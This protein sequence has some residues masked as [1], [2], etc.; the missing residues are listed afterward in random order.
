MALSINGPGSTLIVGDSLISTGSSICRFR[1]AD[2][3]RVCTADGRQS[4]VKLSSNPCQLTVVSDGCV[5]V[6]LFGGHVVAL[7][8]HIEPC[9]VIGEGRLHISSGVTGVCVSADAVF[10]SESMA[11]CVSVFRRVDG[12]FVRRIGSL[13]GG[14]VDGQLSWPGALCLTAAGRHIAVTDLGNHRV[15]VFSVTGEFVRNVGAGVLKTPHGIACSV[16]DELVVADRGNGC[17]RVFSD[18]GDLLKTFGEGD[19]TGVV[20]AGDTVL[21]QDC[22]GERCVVWV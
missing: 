6:A 1:F 4:S 9:S 2:G 14:T 22:T 18:V 17:V 21:S 12:A 3:A 19:F 20:I 7:S 13:G 11:H 15:A 16:F 5:Y 8:P 10:V